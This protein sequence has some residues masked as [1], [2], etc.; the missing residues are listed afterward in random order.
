MV[1]L[2]NERQVF[3]PEKRSGIIFQ[4]GLALLLLAVSAFSLYQATQS[5][6]GPQFL[7]YLLLSLV[8]LPI[9]PLL[10]YRMY[11]LNVASY[12]LERDGIFIRWGLRVEQIPIADIL[13]VYLAEE[14]TVPL[15]LPV[16][17][18]PGACVGVRRNPHAARFS[19]PPE[20]EYMAN[21][22][23]SLVL[24]GTE[25]RMYAISPENAQAFM[26]TFQRLTE[27][28]SMGR[29][30]AQSVYPTFLIGRVWSSLPARILL[31]I[32]LF[33]SL[34]LF[35]WTLLAIPTR[36]QVHLGVSNSA[37]PDDMVPAVQ[38]LLL[39]VLNTILVAAD[40][41]LGLFFFRRPEGQTNAFIVWTAGAL[42]P[43]LF[44]GGLFFL[45]RAG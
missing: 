40:L 13:W 42:T 29:M 11:S 2:T 23:R 41:F 27:L 6:I 16:L 36:D 17:R 32:S 45:L 31:G 5:Q 10:G 7:L 28:G 38:L 1:T 26:N 39:P 19:A 25:Q 4:L 43:L 18:W 9:I 30:P 21:S 8:V 15:P 20:I 3:Y 22:A 35:A 37:S 24:V 44:L 33:L 34:A 12:G 14:L